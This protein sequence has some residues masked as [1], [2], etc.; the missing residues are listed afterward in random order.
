MVAGHVDTWFSLGSRC[1]RLIASSASTATSYG[2]TGCEK[3][4]KKQMGTAAGHQRLREEEHLDPH[5]SGSQAADG[6][7]SSTQC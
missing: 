7:H 4:E 2:S 5:L 1:I 6:E 3:D